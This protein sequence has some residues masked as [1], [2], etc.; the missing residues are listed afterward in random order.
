MNK[1][2]LTLAAALIANGASA[3]TKKKV[4]VKVK[5]NTSA[6]KSKYKSALPTGA[7]Y[8]DPKN[9]DTKTSPANDFY[10]YANGAWLDANPVP[11]SETRWGSFNILNEHTQEAIQKILVEVSAKSGSPKGSSEQ[12]VGDMYA[13]GMNEKAIEA[14]GAKPLMPLLQQIDELRTNAELIDYLAEAQKK[15]L[16]GIFGFYVGSDDKEVTKNIGNFFQG[17]LGL[18]DKD[19]YFKTDERAVKIQT[20]YKEYIRTVFMLIGENGRAAADKMNIVYNF[21]TKLAEKSMGRVEMRDPYKLYNKMTLTQLQEKTAGFDWTSWLA[22]LGVRGEKDVIVAQPEFMELAAKMMMKDNL[23][24][25]KD[26]LKFHL[27]SGMS[28]FLS[29]KF[30]DSRFDFY[31]TTLRGQKEQKP[32]WKTV[33]GMVD[34]AVGMEVGKIY[35][36][37]YFTPE[38][39]TRMLDLVNNLQAVYRERIQKLDWMSNATKPQALEKLDAF[40]KKIGYPDTWRSYKGLSISRDNYVQNVL[41]SNVFDFNYNISRLGKPVDRSEWGMTPPTINAYYNPAYNEIVFPAGILQF[42]FFDFGADD[43]VNYGGIGAVIGHEMTHGF[44]DQGAQYAADGNL[45][46]WWSEEDKT[47]FKVKTDAIVAQYNGYTVL[48]TVHVNGE[49]T[50]GENIADLGGVTIAYEA[51]KRTAEFKANKMIDGFSPSQRFFL[52]WAQVWR[53]NSTPEETAQRI[54]TD[55]HSPGVYRCNG[56]LT[57]F[58]PFYEAY[59]LKPGDAMYKAPNERLFVW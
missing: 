19:Y 34:G 11:G 15:G 30:V 33:S 44:D 4:P 36:K 42:P 23:N 55:P 43:A 2:I 59:N 13:S 10:R 28:P 49:L 26:Y 52:S 12:L 47:K 8:I 24:P 58:M 5:P 35:V 39:K 9:M 16:G 41:N 18:P 38:A 45:K 57:N 54:A 7:K 29:K 14:L 48:D 37:K 32:R 17:G 53:A 31:S 20:A 27:V 21:E 3:Q 22:K 1:L 25:W 6:I 51:F 40:V 56:P 50:Q 46:D